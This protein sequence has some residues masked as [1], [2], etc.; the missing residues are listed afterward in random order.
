MPYCD[1]HIFHYSGL[2]CPRCADERRHRESLE[3]SGRLAEESNYRI[4]NPGNYLCPLCRYITLQF[5]A[6]RCPKCHG[7]ID[8]KY[9]AVVAE[10]R[11]VSENER[12]ERRAEWARGEPARRAAERRKKSIERWDQFFAIYFVY[13]LPILGIAA[14]VGIKHLSSPTTWSTKY[15]WLLFFLIPWLN[16]LLYIIGLFTAERPLLLRIL[17]VLVATGALGWLL[18][19]GRR[20]RS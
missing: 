9:W 14:T 17:I 7:T 5:E 11:R 18:N 10:E 16:W 20:L 4:S 6:L 8:D 12:Q 19:V 15:Y 3:E 13:L 2:K 1:E